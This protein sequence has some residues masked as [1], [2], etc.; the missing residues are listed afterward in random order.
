MT[1]STF[2]AGTPEEVLA[3]RLILSDYFMD[4]NQPLVAAA[5]RLPAALGFPMIE[6]SVSRRRKRSGQL[7][8]NPK[9]EMVFPVRQA[10]QGPGI[11]RITLGTDTLIPGPHKG[12]NG[13]YWPYVSCRVS[14]SWD[15]YNLAKAGQLDT[16]DMEGMWRCHIRGR[17]E[18]EFDFP[19]HIPGELLQEVA[20]VAKI[21]AHF[22]EREYTDVL[23]NG[24]EVSV[25]LGIT[26]DGSWTI[27]GFDRLR[28]KHLLQSYDAKDGRW[29]TTTE[30][31]LLSSLFD[32]LRLR[33]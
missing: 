17:I 26:N 29:I 21:A 30:E 18:T 27:W 5:L 24:M 13:Q 11:A 14:S 10:G 2:F 22:G 6:L 19:G 23:T 1:K 31:E 15:V 3:D 7:D 8:T 4:Q 16:F 32:S 33:I 20:V 12:P 25:D 9:P 28:A